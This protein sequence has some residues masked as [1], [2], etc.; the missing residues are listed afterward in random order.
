MYAWRDMTSKSLI[1]GG[2]SDARLRRA[3]GLTV[4]MVM[5]LLTSCQERHPPQTGSVQLKGSETL[6]PLLTMS[7]EDF[8]TR[9]PQVDVIV[10]GGGSGTGIAALLHGTADIGMASRELSEKERQYADRQGLKI[11]AFG[12]ALDGIAVVVHPHNPVEILTIQQLREIFTGV[13][14]SWQDVGG[15]PNPITL[16]S[17]MDGSGTA[18]LFRQR[19]LGDQNY[20]GGVHQLPTNEGVVTEVAS[21][22]WAIGY[23]SF[24][25]VQVARGRVKTIALQGSPQTPAV[26]PTPDTIRDQSYPLARI[27]HLYTASEP[28]GVVRDFI[29]FCLSSRGQELVSKAGYLA[30]QK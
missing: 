10:Q 25:A 22:P 14:Q 11:Q 16:W 2:V 6:R 20:G 7:A 23:T 19:V 17:R 1:H 28:T 24:G 4:I 9:R 12:I 29:D 3:I 27:L 30:V 13:K 15:A 26:T 8:M 5:S 18:L 21:R